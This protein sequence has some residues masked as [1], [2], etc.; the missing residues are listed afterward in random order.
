MIYSNILKENSCTSLLTFKAVVYS[1]YAHSPLPQ[2]F[3][4]EYHMHHISAK[5]SFFSHHSPILRKIDSLLWKDI[6]STGR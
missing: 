6:A 3:F 4:G 2:T 5:F 1:T